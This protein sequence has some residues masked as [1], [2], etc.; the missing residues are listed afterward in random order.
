[1][2]EEK[3]GNT[4]M[5]SET[6]PFALFLFGDRRLKRTEKGREDTQDF[7]EHRNELVQSQSHR[8]DWILGPRR[9]KPLPMEK[10]LS[11]EELINGIDQDLLFETIDIVVSTIE[12]IKPYVKPLVDSVIKKIKK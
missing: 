2:E 4:V 8:N 6:D 5:D 11:I 9:E 10:N 7:K 1:M 12:K 3:K